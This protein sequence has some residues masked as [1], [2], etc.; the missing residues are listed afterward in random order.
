MPNWQEILAEH[1][2]LAN[3]EASRISVQSRARK[4]KQFTKTLESAAHEASTRHGF[5]ALV[6]AV[7]NSIHQDSSLCYAYESPGAANVSPTLCYL[8]SIA[9]LNEKFF[10]DRLQISE[11]EMTALLRNHVW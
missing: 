7:G 11:T 8:Q 6:V 10:K 4:F 1:E 9:Y 2:T 5:E 3:L